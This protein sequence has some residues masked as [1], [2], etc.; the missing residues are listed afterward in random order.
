[1]GHLNTRVCRSAKYAGKGPEGGVRI[2]ISDD[3][4][5]VPPKIRKQIFQPGFSTKQRGW[6]IGLSLAKRIV[7]E[8]H[9]GRLALVPSD[10][11]ATF[12]I[13]LP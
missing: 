5:G 1:M 3:G 4:P 7:E 13:I 2:R 9:G 6:G 10:R 11:G 8:N 12:E